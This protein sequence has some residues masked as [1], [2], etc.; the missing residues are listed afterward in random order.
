M[1]KLYNKEISMCSTELAADTSL[2]PVWDPSIPFPSAHEM[3]D[4]DVI[5]HVSVEKAKPGGYYYLHEATIQ[6]HKGLFYMGFANHRTAETGDHNEL[7]R[8]CTS[9]NAIQWSEPEIWAE[10]PLINATSINHPLLFSHQGKLYGFFVCW[11]E[12][13]IPMT[14][15]FVL[16]EDNEV[17][18]HRPES[19]IEGFVPFCTPQKMIDGNWLIGGEHWWYDSAVAISDGDNFLKWTR[20][21]IPRPEHMKLLYP[22]SAVVDFGNGHLLNLCRPYNGNSKLQPLHEPQKMPTSPVSESFDGGHTWTPLSMSNFPLSDSQPF[23]GRLSTGHN[24]L[25]TNGLED[26]RGLLS[27]AIAK[28][29]ETVFSKIFKVR[30]NHWPQRRLFSNAVGAKTEW[31]Y[32]NAFEHEGQL[33]IAYTHGKEDCVLSIIPVEVLAE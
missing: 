12:A 5:T 14:E 4:L 32:P 29:N 28:P 25:L 26:G 30:H 11:Y 6:F 31:S 20:I 27:I 17:W 2:T 23:A 19:T 15:I 21:D 3:V 8:G 18:E 10:S 9:K 16:N 1:S 13:H 22:E 24:Y 33:Y 7:V